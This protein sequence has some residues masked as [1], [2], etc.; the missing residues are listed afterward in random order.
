M[1]FVKSCPTDRK[2]LFQ[3]KH[4]RNKLVCK[5]GL[6]IILKSYTQTDMRAPNINPPYF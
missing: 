1:V 2:T 6:Y 4:E 3:E 5:I